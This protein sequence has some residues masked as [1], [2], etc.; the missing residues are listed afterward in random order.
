MP[1]FRIQQQDGPAWQFETRISVIRFGRHPENDCCVEDPSISLFHC[2]LRVT[3]DGLHVRDLN[4]TN[5]T[6]INGEAVQQGCIKP[7]ENLYMGTL[8][9]EL[10]REAE[11]VAIPELSHVQTGPGFLDNGMRSCEY[12]FDLPGIYRCQSCERQWCSDC[13]H[14]I[15]L[16]GKKPLKLCPQCSGHCDRLLPEAPRKKGIKAV[17]KK[18]WK[19]L[20][21]PASRI[22]FISGIPLTLGAACQGTGPSTVHPDPLPRAHA[23]NDYVHERPLFD[24]LRHGF[25][26]VE[27]DIHLMDGEL[28]VAHDEE[29]VKA[30]RTLERLYLEPLMNLAKAGGGR[31]YPDGP[32]LILLVDIKSE[33]E[34]TYGQLKETLVPYRSMLTEFAGSEI[35]TNAVTIILSGNRP[36]KQVLQ[37]EPRWVALDGRLDDLDAGYT[38]AQM[39]LISGSWGDYF[40]WNGQGNLPE[41]ERQL[42]QF[43]VSEVQEEKKWIRFWAVPDT[44]LAWTQLER[45]GVDLIN[46]DDLEGLSR[47]LRE[48][49]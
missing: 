18:A 26:S 3:S 36:I 30:G 15:R 16:V 9:L 31:I 12:H 13:L 34:P 4:S 17:V 40:E 47:T 33:A 25:A 24:A 11:Q 32:S 48:S 20:S 22:L 19:W 35:R 21:R 2:E 6:F 1:T 44:R 14:R 23:H 39:P 46:T 38:A 42:L 49:R 45:A 10:V 41:A 27:A 37:E 28:L 5:G 7:G 29:E 43:L 8:K